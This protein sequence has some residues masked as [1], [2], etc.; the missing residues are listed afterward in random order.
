M[1]AQALALGNDHV[2]AV[3][4][5]SF[6]ASDKKFETM[7]LRLASTEVRAMTHSDLERL[8]DAEGREL[9]R[10]LLQDHLALR[11]YEE[12]AFGVQGPVIGEGGRQLRRL[13]SQVLCVPAL[14]RVS[15]Q[16]LTDRD[17]RN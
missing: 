17:G 13:P 5:P 10:Q 1:Q 2:A 16:G 12:Q 9:M 15:R 3:V 14:Q 7:K 6:A 11:S 8:L 4:R